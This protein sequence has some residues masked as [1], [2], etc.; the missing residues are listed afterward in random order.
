M[1]IK[2]KIIVLLLAISLVF[3]L[4]SCSRELTIGENGNFFVGGEDTGVSATGPKGPTGEEGFY[5]EDGEWGEDGAPGADGDMPTVTSCELVSSSADGSVHTYKLTFSDGKSIDIAVPDGADGDTAAGGVSDD[6]ISAVIKSYVST[7]ESVRVKVDSVKSGTSL[8]I[9][10]ESVISHSLIA[11]TAKIESFPDGAVIRVGQLGG[12]LGSTFAEITN[13]KIA[14]YTIHPV[15]GEK[16]T[17]KS[18]IKHNANLE[19]RFSFKVDAAYGLADVSIIGTERTQNFNSIQWS[20][21]GSGVSIAA[22]GVDLGETSFTYATE[23]YREKIW[24]ITDSSVPASYK[25]SWLNML[26]S[27]G[28]T[29]NLIISSGALNSE[30]ALASFRE[31]LNYGTPVYA[32]WAVGS[33]EAD[34]GAVNAAY[35]ENTEAFIALCREKGIVPVLATVPNTDSADHTHKNAFIK[36]SG[37]RYVDFAFAVSKDSSAVWYEGLFDNEEGMMTENGARAMFARLIVDF[38]EIKTKK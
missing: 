2:A 14:V 11:L 37:E 8:K 15:S 31:T 1:N 27:G 5:G 7:P 16:I 32:F 30:A 22:E 34:N 33:L 28:Y 4:A 26:S 6:S 19:G 38:P 17:V 13:Q 12:E 21:I 25:E 18:P 36:S 10:T 3:A 20:A 9:D 29:E 35:L 23:D 24:V